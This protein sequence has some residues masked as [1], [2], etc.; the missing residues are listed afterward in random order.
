MNRVGADHVEHDVRAED[1]ALPVMMEDRFVRLEREVSH[2]LH[3]AQV[4]N[5]VHRESALQR[6]VPIMES[7]VTIE[8]SCSSLQPSVP[9]GLCG[10]T[11]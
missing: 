9:A 6:A 8:A 3:S 2:V 4:V 1:L 10:R 7:R 11:K 5:A